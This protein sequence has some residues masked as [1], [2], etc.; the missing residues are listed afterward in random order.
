MRRMQFFRY[1]QKDSIGVYKGETKKMD[2]IGRQDRADT[3]SRCRG[4]YWN[5]M[6]RSWKE[7]EEMK[8]TWHG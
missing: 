3:G 8:D 2:N 7:M 4:D 5:R 6:D 1:E